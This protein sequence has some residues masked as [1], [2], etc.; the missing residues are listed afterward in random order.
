MADVRKYIKINPLDLSPDV[1]V[2]VSLPFDGEAVFN[3]TYS[4]KDQI[5]SNLLNVMLTEPGERVFKPNFGV[6]LR[7]YLFENYVDNEDLEIKIR[8]QAELHIPQVELNNVAIIKDPNNH[9]LI[10]SI[11]YT[12]LTN[13][14][15]DAIQVNFSPDSG[16]NTSN[17]SSSPSVGGAGSVY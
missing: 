13:G 11:F 17:G 3:S 7:N 10:V 2:G 5:K 8:T 6:G 12:V 14:E 4:T 9:R 16:I 15:R 1:A